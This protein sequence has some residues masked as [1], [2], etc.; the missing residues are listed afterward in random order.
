MKSRKDFLLGV[1]VVTLGLLAH[2]FNAAI[3]GTWLVV[4]VGAVLIGTSL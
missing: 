4:T 2:I 3:D 1:I